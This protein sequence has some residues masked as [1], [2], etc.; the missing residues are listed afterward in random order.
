MCQFIFHPNRGNYITAAAL[1][2]ASLAVP[3]LLAQEPTLP[4][5]GGSSAE[6][7]VSARV[8]FDYPDAPPATVE[9]DLGRGVIRDLLGLADAAIAGS[10]EGISDPA[11]GAPSENVQFV[12][13]QAAAAREVTD[14]AA[15]IIEEV[16][17][18]VYESLP[19]ANQVGQAMAD[20]YDQKLRDDG[21]ESVLKVQDG[22]DGVR[23]S[24][25]RHAGSTRGV[26]VCVFDG[27]EVVLVSVTGDLSPENVHKLTATA[28]KTAAKLGL[29]QKLDL[30]V[31]EMKRGI[32]R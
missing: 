18:R 10:L 6:N 1:S 12:V 28:A 24:L 23:I 31:G 13:E 3:P 19:E 7:P 30:A 27:R 14:I 25:I 29:L 5:E 11:A 8:V 20:Y 32:S 9:V 22:E 26:F 4:E 16:H 15:G 2:L 17:A 21:W